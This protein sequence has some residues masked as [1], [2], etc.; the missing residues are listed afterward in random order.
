MP[1][2]IL[3]VDGNS[4]NRI[5]LR[6][7]LSAAFYIV[8]QAGS[9]AEAMA[10]VEREQP[11][12]VLVSAALPDMTGETFC[13]KIKIA[14]SGG[15][16]PVVLILPIANRSA[17]ISGLSCGAEEQYL[18]EN[19]NRALG[20][21]EPIAPYLPALRVGIVTEDYTCAMMWKKPLRL[22]PRHIVSCHTPHTLMSDIKTQGVPDILIIGID[23]HNPESGLS[24]LAGLHAQP[25]MRR[26][27]FLAVI[28]NGDNTLAA[29][30][31]DL[32]ASDILL[33]G[34]D[35]DEAVLRLTKL[36]RR[37]HLAD[38]LHHS[39]RD[40]LR[41][42]LIDPLTGLY[43]R[44]YAL[45]QLG[46]MVET[47]AATQQPLVVML[48]D[49]DHF[50]TIND[51]HGHAVGDEVLKTIGRRLNRLMR[52]CDLLARIGGEEFLIA[53][54]NVSTDTARSSA[55]RICTAIGMTPFDL[56][57]LAQPV[58]V[59]VSIGL[60]I[61]DTQTSKPQTSAELLLEQAD[62][63]LYGAKAD[64]RNQVTLSRPA[65]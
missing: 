4:A 2:K 17:L 41:A 32:G 15:D 27:M 21:G 20:F 22:H 36:A 16:R 45:P 53:M 24:L 46:K 56:P 7:K 64:G 13:K 61:Y 49:I 58:P 43:N 35:D 52:P 23:G 38:R 12:L 48:A 30:A 63:A 42:A 25:A 33:N 8:C 47:S 37:K 10:I 5:V 60:S 51:S 39:V 57:E 65:A 28:G 44:R 6:A 50:K 14:E 34:F 18:R 31:L 59:T 26:T 9:G 40:G 62:Q 3:I 1:S 55:C 19:S 54:P 11:D 29:D